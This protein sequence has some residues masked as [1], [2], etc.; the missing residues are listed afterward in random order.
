MTVRR[1]VHETT[2]EG[3]QKALKSMQALSVSE[4]RIDGAEERGGFGDKLWRIT[5]STMPP[6]DSHREQILVTKDYG[7]YCRVLLQLIELRKAARSPGT[8]PR[9]ADSSVG[10]RRRGA[11]AA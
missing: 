10:T 5:W 4:T 8:A 6:L 3:I 1:K 2:P 7:R 11:G 9:R